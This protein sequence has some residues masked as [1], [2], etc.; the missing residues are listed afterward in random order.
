MPTYQPPVK[1]SILVTGADGSVPKQAG[2]NAWVRVEDSRGNQFD[3]Q[4]DRLDFWCAR[5]VNVVPNYPIHIG[6]SAR[7]PVTAE[8]KTTPRKPTP[9]VSDDTKGGRK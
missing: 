9:P 2:R 3:V 4:V 6:T 8:R 1:T 7:V 5:G